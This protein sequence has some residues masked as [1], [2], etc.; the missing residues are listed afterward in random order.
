[1]VDSFESKGFDSLFTFATRLGSNSI[2]GNGFPMHQESQSH[3]VK[4]QAA[5]CDLAGVQ[6][7]ERN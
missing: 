5:E 2:A 4:V 7:A 1:M 6:N 3:R